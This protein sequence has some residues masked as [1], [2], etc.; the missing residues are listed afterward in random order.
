MS[1]VTVRKIKIRA[2]LSSAHLVALLDEFE[3]LGGMQLQL[4]GG[5]LF[6]RKETRDL[7]RHLQQRQFVV[8][9]ISNLT[10]LDDELMDLI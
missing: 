9:L 7:L 2:K 6:I 3:A 4:T 8:S 1:T 5:E 10:L